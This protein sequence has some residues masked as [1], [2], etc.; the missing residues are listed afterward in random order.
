MTN[1]C[2]ECKFCKKI[3]GRIKIYWHCSQHKAQVY[4]TG[5]ATCPMFKEKEN[6]DGNV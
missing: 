3:N 6:Q 1:M 2:S 5:G 4:P